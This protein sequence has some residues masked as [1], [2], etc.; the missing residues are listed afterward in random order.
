MLL[1]ELYEAMAQYNFVPQ[2]N[3][4]ED[5]R[6]TSGLIFIAG[7]TIITLHQMTWDIL[8]PVRNTQANGQVI[9]GSVANT[10]STSANGY[11]EPPYKSASLA[12]EGVI[13]QDTQLCRVYT[14]G[15][16]ERSWCMLRKDVIGLSPQQIQQ[17]WALPEV[18]TD[19]CD[20]EAAGIPAR[21]GIAGE[22]NFGKG[23]N[24]Q[25]ELLQRG[26]RFSNARPISPSGAQ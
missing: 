18:P 11:T 10:R 16:M 2:S 23:G 3:L 7:M 12:S 17:K 14:G 22:N 15:R 1:S 24:V 4:V 9:S 19:I 6:V 20:V 5:I 21:V 13:A 26:A 25:V 8:Y